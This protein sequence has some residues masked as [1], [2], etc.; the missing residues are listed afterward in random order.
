M[1]YDGYLSDTKVFT[2]KLS[3]GQQTEKN[4]EKPNDIVE[5]GEREK[6]NDDCRNG[7]E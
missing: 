4:E 2:E 5:N 7:R 6:E 3:K 1:I